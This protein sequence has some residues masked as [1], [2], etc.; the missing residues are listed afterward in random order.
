MNIN[1][2]IILP[3]GEYDLEIFQEVVD[4]FSTHV[5]WTFETKCGELIDIKLI[6][7]EGEE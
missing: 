7:D 2:K 1:K 4:G 6:K 5:D 3:I